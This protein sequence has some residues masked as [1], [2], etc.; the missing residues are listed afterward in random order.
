MIAYAKYRGDEEYIK[1]ATST[2]VKL[3]EDAKFN[4]GDALYN[5]K[6]IERLQ[7]GLE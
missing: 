6:L 1:V 3:C 5:K 2:G 4:K 7:D